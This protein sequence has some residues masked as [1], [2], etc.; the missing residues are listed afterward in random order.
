MTLGNQYL[1]FTHRPQ[2]E[3]LLSGNIRSSRYTWMAIGARLTHSEGTV[4][5]CFCLQAKLILFFSC[6]LKCVSRECSGCFSSW[7]LNQG[8]FT[9]E[10]RWQE[11][12]D[13]RQLWARSSV[14]VGS[15]RDGGPMAEVPPIRIHKTKT[16]DC[17]SKHGP[18]LLP[19]GQELGIIS[20]KQ[21]G[22]L[23]LMHTN[24]HGHTFRD[25][26]TCLTQE[27]MAKSHRGK[28]RLKDIFF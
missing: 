5:Q 2:E 19:G 8:I 23:F 13:T 25:Y 6:V 4:D 24:T 1:L 20:P 15:Q 12:V 21:E 14:S 18:L 26:M 10:W 11:L 7:L 17:V 9:L 28:R 27:P 3:F 22:Q 16:V